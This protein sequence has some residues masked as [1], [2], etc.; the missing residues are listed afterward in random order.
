VSIPLRIRE[1]FRTLR[2]LSLYYHCSGSV[3][4]PFA[5]GSL[6]HVAEYMSHLAQSLSKEFQSP[7][8]RGSLSHWRLLGHMSI[9]MEY[10]SQSPSHRG[11]HC[12][13][14]G[15]SRYTT[16]TFD[17]NPL[18]IGEPTATALVHDVTWFFLLIS[19]PFASGNPLQPT[20]FYAL[21]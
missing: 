10:R 17:L 4:I 11:T 6:S 1:V 3:S 12:N 16:F 20:T 19:I 15:R 9:G 21:M 5:S 2:T 7:S 14:T 18:R 8:H 13:L